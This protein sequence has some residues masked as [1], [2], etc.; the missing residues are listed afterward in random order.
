MTKQKFELPFIGCETFENSGMDILYSNNG[1]CSVIFRMEN[2]A[3]QYCADAELYDAYHFMFMQIV[4]LLAENYII[5]KTDVVSTQY[6]SRPVSKETDFL[7][8]KFFEHFKGRPY[9]KVETYLTITRSKTNKNA[10]FTYREEDMGDFINKVSKIDDILSSCN[11]AHHLLNKREINLLHK[12]IL[13]FNFKDEKFGLNNFRADEFGIYTEHKTAKSISLIDIED[14]NFPANVQTHYIDGAYGADFPVDNLTFI[15]NLPADTVLL[16]QVIQLPEQRRVKT[17]LERKKKRHTS[18]AAADK[19]N[20]LAANDIEDAFLDIA[21]NNEMLVYCH[22]NLFIVDEPEHIAKTVNAVENALFAINMTPNKNNFN[23]LE[24]YRAAIPGNAGELKDYDLFLTSRPAALALLF[25]ERIPQ[26]EN[27]DYL[28]WFT[29]RQGAPIGIDTSQLP[30]QNGRINNR[31]RFVLGPS[32][33]GKSF[34]TNTYAKQCW[35]LGA[36]IV[37]VDTGHSYSGLCEYVGDKYITYTEEKPITMNPFH[38]DEVENNEEKRQLLKELIGLIWKGTGRNAELTEVESDILTKCI[39]Y[40]YDD[41]FTHKGKGEVKE[42]SFNSFYEFSGKT[43]KAIIEEK[44]VNFDIDQYLFILE[45]FYKGGI[46]ERVLNDNADTTLF[47]ERFIVFEI[48][49]IKEN[50][51]LFPIVTLIIMDVFI[52]KMRH[53]KNKKILIIE[54]AWKAIASPMMAGYILYLYKTVR[55]FS[56]E[57]IVV[58]QELD[59]IIGNPIVKDSI[60]NNSDTVMLLDQ[61]KF[62]ERFDTIA[63]LLSITSIERQKIFTINNLDN[64]SDRNR[65]KEVYIKRGQKGEVYGV[66]VPVEEY[67]TYTTERD[68]KEAFTVYLNRYKNFGRAMD[69]FMKDLVQ[70]N[71]KLP[72]FVQKINKGIK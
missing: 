66:E 24:L 31:N 4:K 3:E 16:N 55:K 40:Y 44:H 50:K 53:K 7:S 72:Q 12:K 20:L 23:Q 54:E 70:S 36:D 27:S 43:I 38:I 59:D 1:D 19:E 32:G 63:D 48:D 39:K 65:F 56:G 34:F 71:L 30:M 13:A 45:K 57:A 17:D 58:T 67:L 37:I 62:K 5:Q 41:Y 51:L 52:Q 14:M 42:L 60:I 6:F 69:S 46:Y 8:R 49:N 2:L 26:T 15:L 61:T 21:E 35:E 64:K 29:D 18:M 68:E 33:S 25:K 47:N 10:F 22:F 9:K 11:I 28:L